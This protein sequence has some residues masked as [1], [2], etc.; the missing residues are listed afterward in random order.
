M[1][2]AP[3]RAQAPP[4]AAGAAAA[5]GRPA[6][7]Q[8]VAGRVLRPT[9]GGDRPAPQ[10]WVTLHRVGPDAAG[11][12]DSLRVGADGRFGFTYR[13]TGSPEAVYFVSA[14]FGGIA[15]LAEPIRGDAPSATADIT[16]FDTTSAPVPLTVRGRHLIVSAAGPSGR[17]TVT[18]VYEVSNDTTVTA[19][20]PRNGTTFVA[21]L[22]PGAT[23]PQVGTGDV[24]A[25]AVSFAGGK[26]LVAAPFAPGLKQLSFAYTLGP[27]AFPLRV[28]VPGGAEVLEVL[29]EEPTA[30]ASG[31]GLAPVGAATLAGRSYQRFLAQSVP[32]SALAQVDVA[33]PPAVSRRG[34]LA[35]LAAVI[36][37][38]MLAALFR[39]LTARRPRPAAAAPMPTTERLARE[40]A[41]LDAA[42]E[43]D[44]AGRA[45]YEARRAELKAQ[46]SA[47][48][49]ARR[50]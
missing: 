31:A 48:L 32:G 39:A 24:S 21:P 23:L 2:A 26:A 7:D 5:A 47:A 41:A 34:Y 28:L 33:A 35:A 12:L 46:L 6:A 20:A 50:A 22:P 10:S 19:V 1:R 14:S 43:R 36:G 4:P 49:A 16:V 38:A 30:R 18:E 45:Q 13:R 3:A 42:F 9:P 8:R 27:E 29:T 15:Y 25:A 11:P 37:A 44:G 40:I 17:R